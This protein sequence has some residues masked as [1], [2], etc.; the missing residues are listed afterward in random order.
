[1]DKDKKDNHGVFLFTVDTL[2]GFLFR[3]D[4]DQAMEGYFHF[5]VVYTLGNQELITLAMSCALLETLAIKFQ[6]LC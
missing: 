2:G 4:N 6:D 1:V 5:S 3:E